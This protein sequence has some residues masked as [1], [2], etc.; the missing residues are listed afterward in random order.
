MARTQTKVHTTIVLIDLVVV[1]LEGHAPLSVFAGDARDKR[2]KEEL[3]R[4]ARIDP[5]M[6]QR[7]LLHA[8][9][10]WADQQRRPGDLYIPGR[11]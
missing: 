1:D 4:S 5:Q 8:A 9:A 6:S 7:A 10:E 3:K 11:M 2:N